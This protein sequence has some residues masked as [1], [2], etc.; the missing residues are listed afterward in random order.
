MGRRRGAHA[1]G[2]A[3]HLSFTTCKARMRARVAIARAAQP[4]RRRAHLRPPNQAV[5]WRAVGRGPCAGA[6]LVSASTSS[7]T[8]PEKIRIMK[9][10]EADVENKPN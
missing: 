8:Y 1:T 10:N 5:C 2:A 9:I 7:T 3:H 4:D 6:V